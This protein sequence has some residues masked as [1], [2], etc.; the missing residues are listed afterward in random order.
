M[1]HQ[2]ADALFIFLPLCPWAWPNDPVWTKEIRPGE[3]GAFL[4]WL[5]P[6]LV[7]YFNLLPERTVTV[8]PGCTAAFLQP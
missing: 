1:I 2:L 7:S 3:M 6:L 4:V 8:M 5:L